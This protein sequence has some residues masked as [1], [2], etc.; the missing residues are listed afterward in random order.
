MSRLKQL[1]LNAIP[2]ELTK[3]NFL[4]ALYVLVNGFPISIITWTK[5]IAD[6]LL[7]FRRTFVVVLLVVIFGDQHTAP[8]NPPGVVPARALQ[9][10]PS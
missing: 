7:V 9:S 6:C 3:L 4:T 10:L 2:E 1:F 5:S 8:Q